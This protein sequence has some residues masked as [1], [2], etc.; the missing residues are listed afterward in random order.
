MYTTEL[1]EQLGVALE[2]G[3]GDK[4]VLYILLIASGKSRHVAILKLIR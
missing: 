2:N 1:P 3:S 4:V